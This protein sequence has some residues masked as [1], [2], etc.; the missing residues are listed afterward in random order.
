M[1]FAPS[2]HQTNIAQRTNT[3]ALSLWG[4]PSQKD[5]ESEKSAALPFAPRPKL[6]DGTMAGDVGFE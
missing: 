5:G 2:N 3:V 1:A 4:E 6:L